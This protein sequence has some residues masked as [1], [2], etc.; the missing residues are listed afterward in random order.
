MLSEAYGDESFR[1]VFIDKVRYEQRLKEDERFR[2]VDIW[3]VFKQWEQL[4]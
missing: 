1:S 3:R 2:Q 4:E